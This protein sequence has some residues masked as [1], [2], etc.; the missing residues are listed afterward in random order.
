MIPNFLKPYHTNL[1]N[2]I[3]L[4]RKSDGG[5]VIDRRIINKTK[6]VITCGLET[7]WSFEEDFQKRN[8]NCK[9]IAFDHTVDKN[10]W[11]NRF[12]KDF[13]SFLLLKKICTCIHRNS[14]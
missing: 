12:K 3:R 1:S 6:A 5:Y 14:K 8:K 9:I 13:I 4:G 10:F 11:I 7:E 2:L